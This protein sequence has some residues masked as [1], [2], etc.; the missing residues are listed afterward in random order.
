MAISLL[1]LTAQLQVELV[2]ELLEVDVLFD[3]VHVNIAGGILIHFSMEIGC[4]EWIAGHRFVAYALMRVV[5][6]FPMPRWSGSSWN[7][8]RFINNMFS[9]SFGTGWAFFKS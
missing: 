4:V 7:V 9:M 6:I 8:G 1:G 5:G 3:Q 2:E